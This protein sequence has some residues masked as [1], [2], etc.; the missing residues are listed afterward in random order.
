MEK[1]LKIFDLDVA[2]DYDAYLEIWRF[3][4]SRRPHDHPQY[5]HLMRGDKQHPYALVYYEDLCPRIIYAFYQ[6]EIEDVISLEGVDA[7]YRH[8]MSAYG[9]GGPA[10]LDNSDADFDAFWR[11]FDDFLEK[12]RVV[13]E[14]V[15]E[16][17]FEDYKVPRKF[18]GEKQQDNV[19]INLAKTKD[20][21]W[22]SYKYSIR[23]NVKRAL[24]SNLKIQ[25]DFDGS[26]T[27]D[28]VNIYHSTMVRTNAK[29]FFL[30]PY[31]AFV[32]FNSFMSKDGLG[33]YVH[34]IHEEQVIATELLLRSP[35][36]IY[37]FLGGSNMD[38]ANLRPSDFLKHEVCTWAID[39]GLRG[40][41][42]GGGIKPYDGIYTFKL[43]FDQDGAHPFLIQRNVHNPDVYRNLITA[44]AEMENRNSNTWEPR[45]DFFPAYLS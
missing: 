29:K 27:R 33:F 15:R 22:D 12:N 37:S 5:L 26:M 34:V 36:N 28:F 7:N 19:V 6:V 4:S 16:D 32:A 11:L 10:L 43:A 41:V 23:K 44:R 9:Y 35:R 24:S 13:S 1:Y 14:F 2:A 21:L 42:L 31:E 8:I 40:Y 25:F 18:A 17:L 39:N 45:E 38:Y 30:I 3:G 20:E